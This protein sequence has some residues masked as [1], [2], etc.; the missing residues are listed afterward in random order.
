MKYDL[1]KILDDL[2]IEYRYVEHEPI[3]DFESAKFVNEKYDLKGIENKSLFLKGKSGTFYVMIT[4][5]G[6]RFDRS[7][8]KELVGEKVSITTG[9]E[10]VEKTG[11]AVGC[12]AAYGY[13]EDVVFVIDEDMY[14]HELICLSAGTP[15]STVVVN[16]VDLKKVYNTCNNRIISTHLPKE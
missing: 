13:D 9:D 5:E 6:V 3:V 2:A 8:M 10:L 1:R 7:F 15:T 11:Y 16:T 14:E 4:V 12:A